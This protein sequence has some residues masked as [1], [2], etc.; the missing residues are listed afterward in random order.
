MKI[1]YSGE[2]DLCIIVLLH[3]QMAKNPVDMSLLL[4][5][6]RLN[7]D[8]HNSNLQ[9]LHLRNPIPSNPVPTKPLY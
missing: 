3:L 8:F 4:E 6:M 9:H 2:I 5:H 1:F 7:L